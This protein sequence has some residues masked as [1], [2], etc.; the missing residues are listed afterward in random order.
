M[1]LVKPVTKAR[2]EQ[3]NLYIYMY[4][5]VYI[6][7]YM[8]IYICRISSFKFLLHHRRAAEVG[9]R[10]S[11]SPRGDPSSSPPLPLSAPWK[12]N[13][14]SSPVNVRPR[15][16]FD[17]RNFAPCLHWRWG[18]KVF[19]KWGRLS[20]YS[21]YILMQKFFFWIKKTQYKSAVCQLIL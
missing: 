7:T 1:Q 8:Y 5:C 16:S 2:E 3:C 19:L 15:P 13:F 10:L 14:T 9:G 4:I 20:A 18:L 21:S 12:V 17:L 11:G 6:F